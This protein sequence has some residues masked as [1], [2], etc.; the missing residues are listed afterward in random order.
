M[1]E[2]LACVESGLRNWSVRHLSLWTELVCPEL[3][4]SMEVSNSGQDIG[5]V[6]E[7]TAVALFHEIKTKLAFL[8]SKAC[9]K[10]NPKILPHCICL[11]TGSS[12]FTSARQKEIFVS[13]LGFTVVCPMAKHH[14]AHPTSHTWKA[15]M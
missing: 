2:I 15:I 6:E 14:L 8:D 1:A 11:G 3:A 9:T 10:L 4:E 5:D 13:F 7:A 12:F